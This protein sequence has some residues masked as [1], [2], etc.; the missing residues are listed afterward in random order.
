VQEVLLL[1][2]RVL[3]VGWAVRQYLFGSTG[4]ACMKGALAAVTMMMNMG[5]PVVLGMMIGRV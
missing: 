1:L 5:S 3:M 4:I 2:A